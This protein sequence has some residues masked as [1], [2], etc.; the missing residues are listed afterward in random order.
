[1]EKKIYGCILILLSVC[2]LFAQ[3]GTVRGN[4]SLE[5]GD[6]ADFVSVGFQKL[7]KGGY[8]DKKG[9]YEIKNVPVGTHMLTV[10]Y[11]GFKTESIKVSVKNNQVTRVKTVKMKVESGELEE[12][13]VIGSKAER[14]IEELPSMSL[15]ITTPL[16]E[17]PQ[18][19]S[20][21][22]QQTIRDF[23]ITGTAEMSRL[24][25]GIV[26]RYGNDNDFAFIIRGTNATNNI[27]RNGVGSYWWNQQSD[28][29]MIERV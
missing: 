28:A 19:I 24:T 14:Y 3:T 4:I 15:K 23:G 21:A 29:Y 16:I 12:I 17:T 20:V 7:G 1:M 9:F 18:N 10:S 8:T 6:A 2:H 5:N 13:E 26:K 27:F 22:T 25:S 11:V